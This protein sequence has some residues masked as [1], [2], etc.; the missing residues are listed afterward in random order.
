MVP[1]DTNR[2][3]VPNSTPVLLATW[4]RSDRA[5]YV[6]IRN[7]SDTGKLYITNSPTGTQA[8]AYAVGPRDVTGLAIPAASGFMPPAAESV[9]VFAEDTRPVNAVAIIGAH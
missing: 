6:E 9:Y 5:F 1:F 7:D 3:A 4:Q 8:D 2:V